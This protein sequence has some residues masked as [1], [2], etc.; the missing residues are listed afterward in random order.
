MGYQSWVD[1][2]GGIHMDFYFFQLVNKAEVLAGAKP[3]FVET[4]PYS[5]K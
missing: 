1:L 5:Y 3:V 4:G 2:P